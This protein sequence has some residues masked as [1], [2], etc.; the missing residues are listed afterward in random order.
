LDGFFNVDKPAGWT[1]FDVVAALR[2]PLGE[3]R[4]GHA[5]TLDPLATGVLPLGAGYATRLLSYLADSDKEYLATIELGR[6]TDT[7]DAAGQELSRDDWAGVRLEDVVSRLDLFR[8]RIQ[9]RPPAYSAVKVA[10]ERAYRRVRRGESIDFA[11]RE[12][13]IHELELLSFRP[14][15]LDLRVVCS[16]GTYLRSLAHD[17]G[18]ALGSGAFLARLRRSRVGPFHEAEAVPLEE[19]RSAAAK[20]VA[21]DLMRAADTVVRHLDAAIL[22]PPT[23]DDLRQG[24]TVRLYPGSPLASGRRLPLGR[25]G[26]AYTTDGTLIGL[27]EWAAPPALWK[28]VK[29]FTSA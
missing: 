27:I 20:S 25:Q 6:T 14:P 28:P 22:S 11:P 1:S 24:R 4:L 17:L 18:Q 8:G 26:R 12:V 3:K 2:R 15:Q 21:R 7:Y 5:G 13:T 10:G 19:L 9:Q 29:I 16:K 23:A